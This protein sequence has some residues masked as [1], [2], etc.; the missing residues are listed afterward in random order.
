MPA[1]PTTTLSRSDL[2]TVLLATL[3]GA[4]EFYDFVI[5]V[6]FTGVMAS[7]FF[8]AATPEWLR[9]VQTY[10]IFAAGY[11]A[12]PLGGLVMAHFGDRH[13]RKRMF[14]LSVLLMALPTL[15]IGLL[16]TYASAGALAPVLLLLMRLL[17]GAAIGGEVPGAWVFVAEHL[18]P[19]RLGLACGTLTGGLTLGI[20]LGSLM[21]GTLNRALSPDAL[22]AWGWRLAFL[23]GG[24]FG[25]LAVR[26]RAWLEETPLF[27]QLRRE[28]A[29]VKEAPLGIVLRDHRP[30]VLLSMA[31]TWVLTAA[32]IVLILMT[33]ALLKG[34]GID[35]GTALSANSLATLGLTLGCVGA[36]L[37]ADRFGKRR[38]FALGCLALATASEGLY[39]GVRSNPANLPALYLLAGTLTGVVALVPALMVR[40]FPTAV[41][42]SGLSFAY[43]AAYAVF[44]GLTPPFVAYLAR[45]NP[46]APGHYVAGLALLG[47][48]IAAV[49]RPTAG[50]RLQVREP[51]SED[52]AG[53]PRRVPV[54]ERSM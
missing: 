15:A 40:S 18:P 51:R 16:P 53:E 31:L 43:N 52:R 6:Y 47:A 21:A 35:A 2:R 3:G 48:G 26:L 45:W 20:L 28:Q 27:E 9:Q 7:Q 14:T 11:L 13:G 4:L 46:V 41:R 37:L 44:G 8:P 25:L 23:A 39:H 1:T 17:Q 24:A 50:A 38:V 30:A 12:R 5:F 36:G 34:F 10:G 22:H 42:F 33:P 19:A 49:M 54:Q 29:L 32:I